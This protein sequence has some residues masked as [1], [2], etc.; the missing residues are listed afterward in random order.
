MSVR[1]AAP[2]VAATAGPVP[3]SGR[4]RIGR[5]LSPRT[6]I[7][8][9][10][11]AVAVAM[12]CFL[13][14][15]V[16]GSFDFAFPRRATMLGAMVV[17]AFAQGVGTVVFHTVTQNRILTPSIMGFDA[18]YVL[19]Q[20]L[21]VA[22]FGGS[23]LAR[24]D[25]T[26]KL[27]V[28]TALMVALATILYRWL[29]SGKFGS[30]YLLLLVGVVIGM[31]FD[32]LSTFVQRLL[33]PTDYDM[34]SVRLF[35]RLSTVDA[36]HLPLAFAVCGAVAVIFWR[37]R[38]ILDALLLGREMAT[39]IGINHKRELTLMLVLIALLVAF[40]T[41]LV[42]PLTFY[43]FLVA[44]IAYQVAGSFRHEHVMPVA[45][46]LGLLTLVGGQFVMQ[47]IFYAGGFL[48]VVIEFVG[49]LLFLYLLL[50]KGKL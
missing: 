20:T 9:L 1:D 16:R 18:M 35:G 29:F 42:G 11:V 49:G 41:A 6:R 8:L 26:A 3:G 44:T 33:D 28:Q 22:A 23:V 12:A 15:F 31:A 30:L 36:T 43:G 4:S 24:T 40:S 32:S 14:L 46:L 27:V 10:S 37:R 2:Q 48:T 47:H 25:G 19:M 21:L 38:H 5:E 13:L 39:S 45:F 7:V 34:L 17:A 50:R